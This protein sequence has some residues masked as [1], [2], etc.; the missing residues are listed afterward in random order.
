MAT[1]GNQARLEELLRQCHQIVRSWSA[2][3][4]TEWLDEQD[5]GSNV[6]THRASI[7]EYS[8]SLMDILPKLL[9]KIN[10]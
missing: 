10:Q 3:A 8:N 9:E 7:I 2:F 4:R 6:K 5:F 1:T